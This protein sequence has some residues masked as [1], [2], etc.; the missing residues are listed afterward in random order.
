MPQEHASQLADVDDRL[1]NR[2]SATPFNNQWRRHFASELF[3]ISPPESCAQKIQKLHET[4]GRSCAKK[5]EK[6][7]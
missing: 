1:I 7:R 2:C 4:C 3:I 6:L 5:L